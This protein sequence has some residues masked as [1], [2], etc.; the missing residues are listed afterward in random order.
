M[1][2]LLLSFSAC[3]CE[4]EV[5]TSLMFELTNY[6]SGILLPHYLA[7]FPRGL[8]CGCMLPVSWSVGLLPVELVL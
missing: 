4:Y 8:S 7:I 5:R 6:L 1:F 3:L 2:L